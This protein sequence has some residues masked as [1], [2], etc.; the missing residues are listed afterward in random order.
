[1]D[2]FSPFL[3]ARPWCLGRYFWCILHDLDPEISFDPKE[4]NDNGVLG[5][6]RVARYSLMACIS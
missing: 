6:L 4:T 3:R 5:K 1:M 2:Y